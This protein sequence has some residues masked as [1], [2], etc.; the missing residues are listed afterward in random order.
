M[1]VHMCPYKVYV[2]WAKEAEV[3]TEYFF[4]VDDDGKIHSVRWF[5]RGEKREVTNFDL[6]AIFEAIEK[7]G[8]KL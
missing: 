7:F 3:E 6:R 5:E 8:W 1:E 2:V 4:D